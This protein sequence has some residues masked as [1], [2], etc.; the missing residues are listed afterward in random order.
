MEDT[1][2]T[3]GEGIADLRPL[4]RSKDQKAWYWYDW[5]NSAFYTTVLTAVFGPFMIEVAG[6]AAGCADPD[7]TCDATLNV[8]GL[9][10][11]AG[12]LPSYLTT[13]ATIASAF[14][15]PIVG[16]FVD[17]SGRKKLWMSGFAWAASFFVR[18]SSTSRP[19]TSATWSPPAAGRGAT[20]AA[21]SCWRS[22]S[23]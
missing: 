19:R 11:A 5:A 2:M 12:S 15:L 20:S 7:E 8:L 14:V 21:G 10:L 23:S 22:T 3:H 9:H 16:A 17:R 18:S 13:F 6:K 4:A 1:S